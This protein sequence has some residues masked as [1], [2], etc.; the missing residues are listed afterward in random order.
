M[1]GT[2]RL[3]VVAAGAAGLATAGAAAG[4]TTIAYSSQGPSASHIWVMRG[5]GSQKERLTSGAVDDVS[6]ALSPAG[7]RLVFVRR[8]PDRQNELYRVDAMGGG[9]RRL[10]STNAAEANPSWAPGGGLIAFEYGG[11]GRKGKPPFE[12]AAADPRPGFRGT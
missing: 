8:R 1:R 11:A 6:P 3:L 12:R 7:A 2:K 5:D 9:L 10:T 4:S